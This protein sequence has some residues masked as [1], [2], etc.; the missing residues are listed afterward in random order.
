VVYKGS[1]V[2]LIEDGSLKERVD[3]LKKHTEKCELCPRNCKVN[4]REKTGFC[5]AG[6][7]A[8]ISSYVPY[9]GEEDVLVGSKGSGTIFFGYCNMRCVFCQNH[10]LS[11]SGQGMALSNQKLADIMLHM[12]N[13]YGCHNINL[14]TPTHFTANIVESIYIAAKKG[15]IVPIVYN[16]GGYESFNTLKLLDG[17]IDIYMPD[18]K[19]FYNESG[20]KYSQVEDYFDVAKSA[21]IEMDRQVGGLKIHEGIAYRGLLI[22]HLVLPGKTDETK[23]ILN[24]IKRNLSEDVLVNLMDQYYPANLAYKYPQL[25]RRLGYREFKE[26]YNYGKELG[27]RLS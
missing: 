3:K 25:N 12:Q 4:R 11:F 2:K 19:Y 18:F 10:T 21:L 8:I 7:L 22:R 23:E 6:D 15:L 20:R 26:V 9:F 14:V 1:Y 27:L 24:F 5:Q 17:I 13:Y 16:C